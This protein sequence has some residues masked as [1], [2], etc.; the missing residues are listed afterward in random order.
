MKHT[1]IQANLLRRGDLLHLG[2]T[3]YA[4]VAS[5]SLTDDRVSVTVYDDSRPAAKPTL[6]FTVDAMIPVAARN[7]AADDT[8][9]P[10]RQE[11]LLVEALDRDIAQ[12]AAEL[13]ALRKAKSYITGYAEAER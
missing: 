12:A 5:T 9:T 7:L 4:I 8:I 1:P 11:R 3:N 13:A 10:S 2:G 6:H